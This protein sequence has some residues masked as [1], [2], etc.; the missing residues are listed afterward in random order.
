MW[1][2]TLANESND[3]STNLTSTGSCFPSTTVGLAGTTTRS[4]YG[5]ARTASLSTCARCAERP[6]GRGFR[7]NTSSWPT[8]LN[9]IRGLFYRIGYEKWIV[10]SFVLVFPFFFFCPFLIIIIIII[11]F[12][13]FS[14][15]LSLEGVGWG[16]VAGGYSVNLLA[17]FFSVSLW[18]VY[19]LFFGYCICFSLLLVSRHRLC[20]P[21]SLCFLFPLFVFLSF[22]ST[23]CFR[24]FCLFVEAGLASIHCGHIYF[25]SFF[26]C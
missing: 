19:S 23:Y 24:L 22:P 17:G 12:F 16:G 1:A 25:S 15:S 8:C 13:F 10:F 2:S 11:F 5:F 4:V 21:F 7:L 26:C 9:T 20:L 6:T 3:T 14:L 18:S